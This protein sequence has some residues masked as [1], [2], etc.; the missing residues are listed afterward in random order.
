MCAKKPGSFLNQNVK[1]KVSLPEFTSVD[2]RKI[3]GLDIFYYWQL[4]L[5]LVSTLVAHWYRIAY[6]R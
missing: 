6:F 3:G 1:Q 2:I 4:F 5:H